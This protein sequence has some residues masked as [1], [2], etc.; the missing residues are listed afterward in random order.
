MKLKANKVPIKFLV[1]KWQC[2]HCACK[3][4]VIVSAD[5]IKL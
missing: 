2:G 5:K 4:D 1:D 3:I